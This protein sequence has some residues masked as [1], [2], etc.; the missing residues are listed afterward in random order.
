MNPNAGQTEKKL[1]ESPG[2]EPNE[3]SPESETKISTMS[4]PSDGKPDEPSSP[5]PKENQPIPSP[6]ELAWKTIYTDAGITIDETFFPYLTWAQGLKSHKDLIKQAIE[7]IP[8][9]LVEQRINAGQNL[10]LIRTP[11]GG[12]RCEFLYPARVFKP[13]LYLIETYRL[14]TYLGSYSAGHTIN[15]FSLLPGE[16]TRIKIETLQH[17]HSDTAYSF[18]DDTSETSI[19]EFTSEMQNDASNESSYSDESSASVNRSQASEFAYHANIKGGA[20][21]GVYN[22]EAEAGIEGK[23]SS[24]I[25]SNSSVQ[26][27]S[28][29]SQF[30]KNAAKVAS[31][32]VANAS[33]Q[34][35]INLK[36]TTSKDESTKT[37]NERVIQNFNTSRTV[38]YIFRQM[39]QEYYVMLHLVDVQVGIDFGDHSLDG[40][41]ALP[42]L[43]KRLRL[44]L[45]PDHL[46]DVIGMITKQYTEMLDYAGKQAN[47][48]LIET[49]LPVKNPTAADSVWRINPDYTTP[50]TD[51]KNDH[52][53]T[54]DVP[55]V[56]VNIHK[57]AMRTDGVMVEALLGQNPALDEETY[58]II[59]EIHREQRLKN[60]LLDLRLDT[61]RKGVDRQATLFTKVFPGPMDVQNDPR[62]VELIKRL[63][64]ALMNG[65]NFESPNTDESEEEGNS[66]G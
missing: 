53:F 20:D 5:P 50:Y 57:L 1:S 38:N 34:R 61:V 32:Q 7:S 15:T 55:G 41:A 12:Y 66:E 6:L 10:I 56:I 9:E 14:S 60:D 33:R 46:A 18:L 59:R 17:I 63:F 49:V 48:F 42:E 11:T 65:N 36:T 31:S 39:N 29:R 28:A 44:A 52:K 64:P 2:S 26:I 51:D 62:Q 22:V 21:W 54:F 45:K 47:G 23:L 35:Q 37:L 27:G 13:T 25:Q 3:S 30:S 24:D 43:G 8:F 4:V 58:A 19:N 16:Q 40:V